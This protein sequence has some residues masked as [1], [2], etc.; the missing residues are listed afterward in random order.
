MILALLK[1]R[2]TSAH[3]RLEQGL[4]LEKRLQ[5]LTDYRRLLQGFLGLY[6]PLEMALGSVLEA[7]ALPL[8]FAARRKVPL[9]ESDLGALGLS[10]AEV[11]AVPRCTALP[12][13]PDLPEALGCLYVLE[14][15]TLGGQ[16]MARYAARTW[17]LTPQ[18]GS[19]FFSSYGTQVGKRWQTFGTVLHT[20]AIPDQ[21]ER[22]LDT[23]CATFAT[24]E[25]W[26]LST[27]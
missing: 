20:W 22:I 15:A 13:L 12:P 19:A 8:D 3:T 2:T 4:D 14:G 21:Y 9:L 11:Q 16:V 1:Q 25:H 23:A 24:F 7:H 27:H 10:A 26:L 18:Q 5:S 6:A 17:G